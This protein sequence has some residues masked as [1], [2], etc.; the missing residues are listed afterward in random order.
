MMLESRWVS[1]SLNAALAMK[2]NHTRGAQHGGHIW[3]TW[4]RTMRT[5]SR[6]IRAPTHFTAI[7]ESTAVQW[8]L[9][10]RVPWSHRDRNLRTFFFSSPRV[11]KP[12]PTQLRR[13]K[14]TATALCSVFSS[15]WS[16]NGSRKFVT[17][18]FPH[19]FLIMTRHIFEY[20]STNKYWSTVLIIDFVFDIW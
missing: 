20:Q 6:T 10:S 11:S 14:K 19:F 12:L 7:L 17:S 5:P 2:S 15:Q 9:L 3:N 13:L 1:V 16:M 8:P 4:T 18:T